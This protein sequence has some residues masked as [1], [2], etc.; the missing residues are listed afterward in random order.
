MVFFIA[1]AHVLS[2]L[3]NLKLPLTYNGKSEIGI[4]C[5]LIADII[6]KVLQKCSFSPLPNT[7]FAFV[8]MAT[9][10]FP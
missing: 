6:T 5:Y 1:V 3:C 7:I 10:K 2:L 9:L 4:Y 8:A